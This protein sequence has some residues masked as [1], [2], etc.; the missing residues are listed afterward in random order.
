MALD[1]ILVRTKKESSMKLFKFILGK[2]LGGLVAVSAASLMIGVW[3]T[4]AIPEQLLVIAGVLLALLTGI[5]VLLTWTGRGKVRMTIG[6]ALAVLLMIVLIAGSVYIW[7]GL[8]TLGNITSSNTETVHMGIYM[9]NE[10][11]RSF[12]DIS[13]AGYQYGILQTVDREAT[14]GALQQLN[15]KLNATVS[16]REYQSPPELVDALLNGEVDAIVLNQAFLEAFADI[17]GFAEKMEKIREAVLQKVEV[18]I[19]E[20]ENPVNPTTGGN[21]PNPD[22]PDTPDKPTQPDKPIVVPQ[23]SNAF[24]IY[25]SGIDT[26]GKVS[27]RSRSDVN[28]LAVVNPDSRQILLVSTPRDY[29]VPLSISYGIPDKLT[30]AGIYGINV[31][32]STLGMLYGLNVDYHFK[33]NF[34]GFQKIVDALDG[35]NVYSQYAFGGEIGT[36]YYSFQKGMNTLNGHQALAFCRIRDAFADGD[37]QRGKNQMAVIKAVIDKAMSPKLLTNYT[38]ILKAVEGSIEMSIPMDVLGDLVS[39]QLSNGGS[40][41]VVSYSVTGTEDWKSTYSTSE[42]L[43]VMRPDYKTVNY[44]KQLIQDVIDGKV[45]KP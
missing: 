29:Y 11:P 41:N 6:I 33:V 38:Q 36:D 37:H 4:R 2:V 9:R 10:D 1:I 44:A 27:T 8:N 28:I 32:K 17:P 45:V 14:D 25:I 20:P 31:S 15:E 40:W 34:S 12:D 30:H 5:V 39:K 21:T 42:V 13:A 43:W 16:T 7:Q 22:N 23:K 3:K 26:A 24:S 18:Q 19:P 35:V